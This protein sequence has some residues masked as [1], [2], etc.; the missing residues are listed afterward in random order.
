MKNL[1]DAARV[2]E[3]KQRKQQHVVMWTGD[4]GTCTWR[5]VGKEISPRWLWPADSQFG[6]IGCGE[7]IGSIHSG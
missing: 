4:V 7:T 3:V 1:F 5:C 2:E 6:C